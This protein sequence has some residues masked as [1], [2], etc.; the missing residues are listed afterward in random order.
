MIKDYYQILGLSSG[1]SQDEIKTAYRKLA[2]D[3]HPD[4]CGNEDSSNFRSIQEAYETIGTVEKREAYDRQLQKKQFHNYQKAPTYSIRFDDNEIFSPLSLDN[5][6]D[7]ILDNMFHADFRSPIVS[8]FD[9]QLELI[10]TQEEAESGGAYPISIPV[11]HACTVCRGKGS[12]RF[13][14]C[15]ACQGHGH[16]TK[17]IIINLQ[18]PPT[19][20]NYSN[21]RIPIQGYG[22]LTITVVIH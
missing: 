3:S 8:D 14:F 7:R 1:C 21:F 13:F 15:D 9:Q 11:C 4:S 18:I 6:F 12:N 17:D 2:R 16:T 19:I 22:I 5:W 20:K 10:L